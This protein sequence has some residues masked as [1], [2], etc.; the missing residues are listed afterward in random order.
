MDLMFSA[1]IYTLN[2]YLLYRLNEKKRNS[3]GKNA[4]NSGSPAIGETQFQ[5]VKFSNS[6]ASIF[7]NPK[8]QNVKYK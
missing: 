2:T 7:P 5:R 8:R 1:V 6:N 3:F 4:K